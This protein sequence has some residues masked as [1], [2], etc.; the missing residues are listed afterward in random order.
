[1][2][3]PQQLHEPAILISNRHLV[4]YTILEVGPSLAL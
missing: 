2:H 4:F 3:H 1:M